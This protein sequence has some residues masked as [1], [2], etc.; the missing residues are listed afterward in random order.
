MA[1]ALLLGEAPDP[2]V[3]AIDPAVFSPRRFA[4]VPA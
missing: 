1:A 4:G 3:A 2:M